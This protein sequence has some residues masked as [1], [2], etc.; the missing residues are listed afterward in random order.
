MYL[1]PFGSEGRTH[2]LAGE[3]GPN[4]DEGKD[5]VHCKKRLAVCPS[6]A[7]ISL[8][9]LSLAGNFYKLFPSRESLVNDIPAGDGKTA[10]LFLQCGT[11]GISRT[12]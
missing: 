2:S 4:S 7:G 6:P 11:L 1:P 3:G 10:V 12:L 5:T 9:K 8:T